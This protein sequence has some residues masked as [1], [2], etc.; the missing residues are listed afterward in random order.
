M[1]GTRVTD[2]TQDPLGESGGAPPPLWFEGTARVVAGLPGVPVAPDRFTEPWRGVYERVLH[3]NGT[4]PLDILSAE[5]ETHACRDDVLRRLLAVDVTVPL[6]DD[7]DAF[8]PPPRRR[9]GGLQ[10]VR[11]SDVVERKITY[12]PGGYV[13]DRA[14]QL[15]VGDPGEG[16]TRLALSL[17]AAVTKG[18]AWPE[19]AET[20]DAGDVLYCG[21]EDTLEEDVKPA[22]R[23][24]GGDPTRF[25]AIDAL[26]ETS[27]DGSEKDATFTLTDA[28]LKAL[29][30]AAGDLRPKVLIIDPITGHLGNV[31]SFRDAE[32]RSRLMPLA[33]I[34]QELCI[35]VVGLAHLNKASQQA[36]QY[37]IGSSI[38]F[39]AVARAVFYVVRDPEDPEGPRRV[40]Y[41]DKANG[42]KPRPPKGYTIL[43]KDG[44]GVVAWDTREVR[45]TLNDAL[46]RPNASQPE[47]RT[48]E[49][50]AEHLLI[51]VFADMRPQ[52]A[53]DIQKVAA[54]AGIKDWTL[55]RARRKLGID[56]ERAGGLGSDGGW[57]W[58]PTRPL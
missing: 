30:E 47:D 35:G 53:K 46:A 15:L 24:M 38:A 9:V 3:H 22:F 51:T 26:V 2:N 40:L 52:P 14:F 32:V 4:P 36:V 12:L 54:E 33:R 19:G 20:C 55:T 39:R 41:Q 45:G 5:L 18:R 48:L 31:D 17:G 1:Q 28:G 7:Q 13:R 34:A 11:L 44:I 27:R 37:R 6:L 58:K 50:E 56:S 25:H 8:R 49:S 10:L 57:M 42:G 23:E 43:D 29:R 21:H 16:K